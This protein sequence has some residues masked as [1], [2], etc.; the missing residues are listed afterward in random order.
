V[1][2]TTTTSGTKQSIGAAKVLRCRRGMV[3]ATKRVHGKKVVACVARKKRHVKHV[4]VVI[5]RREPVFTG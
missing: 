2:V 3:K 5:H 1:T 4:H